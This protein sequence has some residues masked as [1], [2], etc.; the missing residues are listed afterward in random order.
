MAAEGFSMPNSRKQRRQLL[1]LGTLPT[2]LTDAVSGN[3]TWVAT[4]T[5]KPTTLFKRTTTFQL[6]NGV[7]LAAILRRSA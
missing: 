3:K 6:K 1:Q 7:A 2:A 5:H 4:G